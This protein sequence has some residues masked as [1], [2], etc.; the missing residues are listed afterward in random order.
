MSIIDTHGVANSWLGGIR[1]GQSQ[2]ALREQLAQEAAD[3]EYRDRV[4]GIRQQ[5]YQREA[6]REAAQR[7]ADRAL[8]TQQFDLFS[9]LNGGIGQY[10]GMQPGQP[11]QQ[12]PSPGG[13]NQMGQGQPVQPQMGGMG[14]MGGSG[15][16]SR[17]VFSAASPQVQQ[18]FL[19][20][21]IARR[22]QEDEQNKRTQLAQA[23]EP[24]IQQQFSGDEKNIALA[25]LDAFGMGEL[26]A[27]QLD[28]NLQELKSAAANRQYALQRYQEMNPAPNTM[29]MG[30]DTMPSPDQFQQFGQ[31][32]QD[33]TN[34]SQLDPTTQR[35]AY[36]EFGRASRTDESGLTPEQFEQAVQS[37]LTLN[38]RATR[39][40]AEAYV[41][42]R[43]GFN[44]PLHT[45]ESGNVSGSTRSPNVRTTPEWLELDIDEEEANDEAKLADDLYREVVSNKGS[46]KDRMAALTKRADAYAKRQAVRD[47]RRDLLRQ[48][49]RPTDASSPRPGGDAS[50]SPLGSSDPLDAILDQLSAEDIA[51]LLRGE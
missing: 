37:E 25:H 30:M 16:V 49:S 47:K 41:R 6:D 21:H 45:L 9:A 18:Q 32:A 8:A 33:A 27:D 34:F 24:L 26:T 10:A 3:R 28:R 39:E 44:R 15:G 19:A 46:P 22:R 11:Q 31:Y 17:D 12:Q 13:P 48:S 4:L 36:G 5:E 7:E 23:W 20:Q 51:K 40:T 38:P 50:G 2:L 29:P 14:G 43:L 42:S 1:T 35:Q